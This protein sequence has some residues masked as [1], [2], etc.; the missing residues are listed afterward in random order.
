MLRCF[1]RVIF[2]QVGSAR[3]SR[4][5]IPPAPALISTTP[6]CPTPQC[7]STGSDSFAR[8]RPGG[9][10]L[11]LVNEK[12]LQYV[13]ALSGGE[14]LRTDLAID[15]MIDGFWSSFDTDD[16]IVRDAPG[17]DEVLPWISGHD[18][19]AEIL[20]LGGSSTAA[21]RPSSAV[22]TCRNRVSAAD[23]SSIGYPARAEKPL[24]NDLPLVR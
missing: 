4:A 16:F 15:R 5:D 3:P 24:M 11:R 2:D 1:V 19:D 7:P 22:S 13:F 21:S 12:I 17:T 6:Q 23:R 9:A 20:I 14:S 8:T 18:R 10:A